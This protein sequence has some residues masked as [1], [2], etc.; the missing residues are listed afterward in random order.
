MNLDGK[1]FRVAATAAQGVVSEDTVLEFVQRGVRVLGR[2]QG[3]A[4]IRGYLVGTLTGRSLRFRYAQH[5]AGGHIHGGQSVCDLHALPGGRLRLEEHFAW[6]TRPGSGTNLF[7][8][9]E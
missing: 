8:E 4:V 6:D 3:G 7:E 9:I 1:Q 2:Y 5:E